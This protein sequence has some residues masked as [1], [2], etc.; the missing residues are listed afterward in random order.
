MN[1]NVDFIS[2]EREQVSK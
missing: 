1:E 2:S